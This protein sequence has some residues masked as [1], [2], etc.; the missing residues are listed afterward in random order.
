MVS[1]ILL[2]ITIRLK[3]SP[4]ANFSSMPKSFE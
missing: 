4:A 3:T 1:V 2:T